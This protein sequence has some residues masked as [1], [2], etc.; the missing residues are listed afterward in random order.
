MATEVDQAPARARGYDE[1]AKVDI[2]ERRPLARTITD[3]I[4]N[5]PPEFGV[6]VGLF[7]EWGSGKTLVL[8]FIRENLEARPR[9]TRGHGSRALA[10]Q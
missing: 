6:R 9:G 1:P 3:V 10:I 2:L 4:T 7:G 5:T 8:N